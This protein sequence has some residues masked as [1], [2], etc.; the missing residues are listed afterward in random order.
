MTEPA[1]HIEPVLVLFVADPALK[2]AVLRLPVVLPPTGVSALRG[3]A[4]GPVSFQPLPLECVALR[5]PLV[6]A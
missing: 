4:I 2:F 6:A 1:G 3:P 5:L